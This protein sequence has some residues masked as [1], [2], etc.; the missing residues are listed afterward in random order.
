M[1]TLDSWDVPLC[2]LEHRYHI[3]A[4]SSTP[5]MEAAS[6]TWHHIPEGCTLQYKYLSHHTYPTSN[7]FIAYLLMLGC[8]NEVIMDWAWNLGIKIHTTF[9]KEHFFKSSHLCNQGDGRKLLKLK[10]TCDRREEI[11]GNWTV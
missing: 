8:H 7:T 1:D 5:K 3:S 6:C 10:L 9:G 4:Y 2:S 11:Q